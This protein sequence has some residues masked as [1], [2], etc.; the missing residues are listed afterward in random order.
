MPSLHHLHSPTHLLNT[1]TQP[2]PPPNMMTDS[3]AKDLSSSPSLSDLLPTDVLSRTIAGARSL[4]PPFRNSPPSSP[5]SSPRPSK[6]VSVW[7]KD[8]YRRPYTHSPDRTKGNTHGL[9]ESIS[10]IYANTPR[11][12]KLDRVIED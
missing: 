9:G 1:H 2:Q 4:L 8:F 6:L 12:I 7:Q 3:Y 5:S 10:E 11:P